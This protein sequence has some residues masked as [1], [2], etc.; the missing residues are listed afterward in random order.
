MLGRNRKFSE[1]CERRG[2]TSDVTTVAHH[3]I[4]VVSV[5]TFHVFTEIRAGRGQLLGQKAEGETWLN[6]T[7]N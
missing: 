4:T 6:A 3:H 5:A 2:V 7:Q 1:G